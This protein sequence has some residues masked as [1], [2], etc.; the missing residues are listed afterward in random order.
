MAAV[1][2]TDTEKVS[3][4][5]AAT[6]KRGN[7]TQM[8]AGTTSW[9]VDNPNVLTLN[10]SAD[11]STCD[12]L[13]AGPLGTATVT[14][15]VADTSGNTLAAGTLDVTVQSGAATQISVTPTTPVEQ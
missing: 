7:P 11:G 9:S 5:I 8:P 1:T 6:D 2:M 12:V 4:S 13:A 10:P 3:C 14:V 15:K